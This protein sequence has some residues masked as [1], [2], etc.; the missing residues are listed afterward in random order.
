MKKTRSLSFIT[1][2][3]GLLVSCGNSGNRIARLDGIVLTDS[4]YEVYKRNHPGHDSVADFIL[5]DV[6]ARIAEKEGLLKTPEFEEIKRAA[7]DEALTR[8]FIESKLTLTGFTE[9]EAREFYFRHQE[10]ALASHMLFG[11]REQAE[12]AKNR[13][14]SG[15]SFETLAKELSA[16][17][18]TKDKGG[19]LGWISKGMTVAPFEEALFSG[20]PGDVLGPV[21]TNYGYHLILVRDRKNASE[22]EFAANKS[23][24]MEAMK[25][26]QLS[27]QKEKL[28]GAVRGKYPLKPDEAVLEQDRTTEVYPGDEKA[29]A[30]SVAGNDITL[31]E[32]KLFMAEA[33][34]I[35]GGGHSLGAK[36]KISFMELLADD[37]RLARAAKDEGWDKA[38][39]FRLLRDDMVADKACEAAKS[40][41]LKTFKPDEAVLRNFYQERKD[42]F[43][44]L[45]RVRLNII[46]V[47]KAED[48][49]QIILQSKSADFRS[50]YEKYA[51]KEATG[52]M[53]TGLIEMS[54]LSGMLPPEAPARIAGAGPADVIGPFRFQEG[55]VVMKVVEKV[56]TDS[57]SFEYSREKAREAFIREKGADAFRNYLETE[58][59]KK[60]KIELFNRK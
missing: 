15:D 39:G 46:V 58:G 10:K 49:Q 17:A 19:D 47:T 44:E 56:F 31:K 5:R 2:I 13:L 18:T 35:R 27:T 60:V 51:D 45:A 4:Q 28:L 37:L 8:S 30:G 14:K 40:S 7:S 57:P 33:M 21:K 9:K 41:F 36:T 48:A 34:K 20:K 11:T 55:Y 53:D 23:A 16:D 26:N 25:S 6:A 22:E 42:L 12:M 29:V 32:L 1:L 24:I 43:R 38:D 50:L 3:A 54:A 52:E 59:E